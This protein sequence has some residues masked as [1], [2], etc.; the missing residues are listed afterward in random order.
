MQFLSIIILHTTDL[1]R[2]VPFRAG[3]SILRDLLSYAIDR[4]GLT[5]QNE[6]RVIQYN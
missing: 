2:E 1:A 4:L 6:I 3:N 5:V